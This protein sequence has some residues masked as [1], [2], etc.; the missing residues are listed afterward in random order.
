[1]MVGVY[2]RVF[3]IAPVF[4]AEK[5]DTSRHL[6]EYTS[7]DFEMGYISSFYEIIQMETM[8]LRHT[9]KYLEE[10]YGSELAVLKVKVPEINGIPVIKFIEAKELISRE[11]KREIKDFEDFEPEEEKL[12]SELIMKETGCEFVFVTHYPTKKRPFY[13]MESSE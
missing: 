8:L 1:M 5:H 6:N 7:V 12:L 2:E 3:E 13:A 4:R 9:M 10:N 11:F